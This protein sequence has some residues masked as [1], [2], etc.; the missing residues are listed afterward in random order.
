MDFCLTKYVHAGIRKGE[1]KNLEIT[2]R[3]VLWNQAH[4]GRVLLSLQKF[5]I[6]VRSC[7]DN[8]QR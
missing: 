2:A 8:G 1:K 4:T 6:A 7:L 3:L 5:A